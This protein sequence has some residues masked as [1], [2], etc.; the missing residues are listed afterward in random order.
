MKQSLRTVC[1]RI[2]P[3]IE[4]EALLASLRQFEKTWLAQETVKV[5]LSVPPGVK[6][7][8]LVIGP[9][10]G[11]TT[12]EYHRA[13]SAGA[14]VFG[15]GATRLRSETAAIAGVAMILMPRI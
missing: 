6:S 1:P 11:F 8:L 2:D 7:G 14:E 4:F 10:G 9:E 15:L 3:P 13:Q 12:D 5:R